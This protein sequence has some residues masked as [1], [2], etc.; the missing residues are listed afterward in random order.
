MTGGFSL[1]PLVSG[2]LAEY[3]PAPTTLPYLLHVALV[4]AGLVA[5]A[6][7][8]ETVP[9]RVAGARRAGARPAGPAGRPAGAAR[10]LAPMAVWVF[11]F[12][13]VVVAAVPLLVR[14]DAPPVLL[15]GVLAGITLG[16]GTL[17]AP[18]QRRCRQWTAALGLRAGVSATWWPRRA[19]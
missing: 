16:T 4:V 19:R 6:R 13:T 8:P 3:G 9:P 7:V 12:P 1:G 18:L 15:T 17:A 14:T 5:A 10:V 11:A 2:V